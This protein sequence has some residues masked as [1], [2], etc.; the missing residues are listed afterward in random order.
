MGIIPGKQE[1][2]SFYYHPTYRIFNRMEEFIFIKYLG[3]DYAK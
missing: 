3:G 1:I 2:L